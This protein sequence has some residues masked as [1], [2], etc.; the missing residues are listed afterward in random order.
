MIRSGSSQKGTRQEDGSLLSNV[1]QNL[2]LRVSGVI[3]GT[4]CQWDTVNVCQNASHL[5]KKINRKNGRI[6]LSFHMYMNRSARYFLTALGLVY[7]SPATRCCPRYDIVLGQP[8]LTFE[9]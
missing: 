2:D 3:I 7:R 4:T 8:G 9:W 1:S 5:G 6:S